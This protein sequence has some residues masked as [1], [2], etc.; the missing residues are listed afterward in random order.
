MNI[1][2]IAKKKIRHKCKFVV[3]FSYFGMNVGI[4]YVNIFIT[5]MHLLNF[6]LW[7]CVLCFNIWDDYMARFYYV[8]ISR[9]E[10]PQ[11]FWLDPRFSRNPKLKWILKWLP[12]DRDYFKV[13]FFKREKFSN[14][15]VPYIYLLTRNL[16][17][18][19]KSC[20]HCHAFCSRW[21]VP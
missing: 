5:S 21:I 12:L 19:F 1:Q 13:Y 9:K 3:F 7:V 11:K 2:K 15:P 4:L 17:F 8:A 14:N 20:S 18:C 16:S 6:M 10:V